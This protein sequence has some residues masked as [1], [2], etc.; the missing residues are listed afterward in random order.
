MD[1]LRKVNEDPAN[2]RAASPLVR[3]NV[4]L[5]VVPPATFNSLPRSLRGR[6]LTSRSLERSNSATASP[7]PAAG[8]L[9]KSMQDFQTQFPDSYSAMAAAQIPSRSRDQW[10]SAN[11]GISESEKAAVDKIDI[12]VDS[13]E[14]EEN[15]TAVIF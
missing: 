12:I 8:T 13:Y 10:L 14:N 1:D 2:P 3:S 15:M 4:D 5:Q 11:P 6:D 9:P 7:K